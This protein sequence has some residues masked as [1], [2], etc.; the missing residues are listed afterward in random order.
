MVEC[1]ISYGFLVLQECA[2]LGIEGDDIPRELRGLTK[3]LPELLYEAANLLKGD[4]ITEAVS[5]YSQFTRHTCQGK[6]EP[7]EAPLLPRIAE[8]QGA[9]LILG[10]QGPT[11]EAKG[12]A[13]SSSQ[14]HLFVSVHID[15]S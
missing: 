12:K 2:A 1:G 9:E 15:S 5:Y 11:V 6:A 8:I 7:S 13:G 4:S 10:S 3:K 14:N